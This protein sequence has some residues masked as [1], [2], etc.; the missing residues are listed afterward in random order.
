MKFSK[1]LNNKYNVHY[2]VYVL[3]VIA[4]QAI[5][6]VRVTGTG[7]QWAFANTLIGVLIFLMI[8]LRGGVKEYLTKVHLISLLLFVLL[9][10]PFFRHF[11]S[12]T[13]YDFQLVGRYI[14]A[15]LCSAIIIKWARKLFEKKAF[16]FRL[17]FTAIIWILMLAFSIISK[18]E[19]PWPIWA[20][21][22]L[23][24]FYFEPITEDEKRALFNGLTDGIIISF[25]LLESFALLHC[26]YDQLRYCAC[27]SNSDCSAK[28]F[29]ISYIGFLGKFYLSKKENKAK[30]IQ[31]TSFLFAA[32]M[33]GF[34]FFTMTRSSLLGMGFATVVFFVVERYALN[35][36]V[37]V[38][39]KNTILFG[40]AVI[41][42]IPIVY[43]AIRYIPAFRHHPVF[44]S[45]YSEKRVHSWDPIDSEKYVGFD[46][47][48]GTIFKRFKPK[49]VSDIHMD[50]TS[51][52]ASSDVAVA[53][54]SEG[55]GDGSVLAIPKVLSE[56]GE[57]V[58]EYEDGIEP[59]RDGVHPVY[60]HLNYNN[61]FERIIG[62]RKYLYSYFFEVSGFMGNKEEYP[63]CVIYMNKPYTSAHNS[64]IDYTLRYGYIAGFF[65]AILQ[66]I[67]VISSIRKV[68]TTEG[69]EKDLSVLCL[70]VSAAFFGWGLFYSV[71]FMGEILDSIYWI[72]LMPLMY[73]KSEDN[74]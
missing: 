29:T 23:G 54:E 22:M 19:S 5:N 52:I 42:S 7:G 26:P 67:A 60:I 34:W 56:N 11:S 40:L 37:K 49:N 57:R 66:V 21:V 24:S 45:G 35:T 39:I 8:L 51:K 44:L 59:G 47:V 2:V 3:I 64:T 27:F 25:F 68:K 62:V 53:K 6:F 50:F 74:N 12:G 31:L 71:L 55:D 4:L 58:L 69:S 72:A 14:N 46:E 17:S 48:M 18:N 30:W 16:N 32:A 61:V 20:L 13:D 10:F 1:W 65:F 41:V 63:T 15:Y 28:F 33:W 36:S 70:L 38:I 9:F 43:G 73:N